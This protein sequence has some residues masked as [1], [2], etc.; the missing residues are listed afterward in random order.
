M[1]A[2]KKD[3]EL[4]PAKDAE[5]KE[6]LKNLQL[7]KK[8]YLDDLFRIEDEIRVIDKAYFTIKVSGRLGYDEIDRFITRLD[9]NEKML[10]KQS[11]CKHNKLIWKSD[12]Y[13]SCND[14]YV[15]ICPDC[16]LIFSYK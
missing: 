11:E 5:I 7:F 2:T 15:L 6:I 8:A 13:F 3:Y 4:I 16:E 10:I 12:G 9:E 1:E 14:E